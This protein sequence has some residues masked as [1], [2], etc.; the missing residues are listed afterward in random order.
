MFVSMQLTCI[1]TVRIITRPC[2]I[3]HQP[4]QGR[5][6]HIP[7]P[8]FNLRQAWGVGRGA[9]TRNSLQY[10]PPAGKGVNPPG[11]LAKRPP[12]AVCQ[13]RS[14][15]PGFLSR[16]RSSPGVHCRRECDQDVRDFQLVRTPARRLTPGARAPV[17]GLRH[18]GLRRASTR[19]PSPY[20][21][22]RRFRPQ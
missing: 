22:A 9:F 11:R 6:A 4:S 13:G 16:G 12:W 1:Y 2:V 20:V 10:N 8:R 18:F 15:W 5:I 21:P 3:T 19:I 14:D 7:R 17:R